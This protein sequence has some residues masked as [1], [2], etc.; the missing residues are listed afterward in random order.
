MID[1]PIYFNTVFVS[2]SHQAPAFLS[3]SEKKSDKG[4][5]EVLESPTWQ[6]W[7]EWSNTCLVLYKGL[8]ATYHLFFRVRKIALR[9]VHFI[10]CSFSMWSVIWGVDD[11]KLALVLQN[12]TPHSRNKEQLS[13]HKTHPTWF[14]TLQYPSSLKRKTH[15]GKSLFEFYT[16][17]PPLTVM[18]GMLPL[19]AVAGRVNG[20]AAFTSWRN[21][22]RW[23]RWH[24]NGAQGKDSGGWVGLDGA[25]VCDFGW[26]TKWRKKRKRLWWY[27]NNA[28]KNW[29]WQMLR[30]Q[31]VNENCIIFF[32]TGMVLWSCRWDIH[33]TSKMSRTWLFY[34]KT[35]IYDL[36]RVQEP[37]DESYFC[38][39]FYGEQPIFHA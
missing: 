7:K 17:S 29:Y 11:C 12:D 20:R 21:V 4:L 38:W 22:G 18:L 30:N 32:F 3:P 13:Y 14:Q 15:F 10:F 24:P 8:F 37:R 16:S 33:W 39:F 6:E 25:G 34:K 35:V 1:R 26:K 19:S 31:N 36:C 2:P 9:C 28:W 27:W 23:R 5:K